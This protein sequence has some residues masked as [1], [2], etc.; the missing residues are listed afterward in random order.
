LQ[1][2]VVTHPKLFTRAVLSAVVLTALADVLVYGA[3]P[4]ISYGILA[5]AITAGILLC[6]GREGLGFKTLVLCALLGGI[7]VQ[8]LIQP[9]A[10]GFFVGILLVAVLSLHT[11][12]RFASDPAAF[13][14]R[15]FF[16]SLASIWLGTAELVGRISTGAGK[17]RIRAPKWW[18]VAVPAFLVLLF[19]MMLANANP[20]FNK[21]IS[22]AWHNTW[23]EVADI[24]SRLNLLRLLFWALFF[25]C[26]YGIIR[27]GRTIP[28]RGEPDGKPEKS[29]RADPRAEFLSCLLSMGGLNVLFVIVNL[30]DVI[31]LWLSTTL[32]EG[33][34][35]A[36]YAHTGSY[37]LIVTVIIS[38]VVVCAFYRKGTMQTR[39]RQARALVYIWVAQNIFL[40]LS[41]LRRL[42]IY[43]DAYG[44]TRWRIAVVFWVALVVCGFVLVIVKV[45]RN[46][47]AWRL[48]KANIVSTLI[49]FYIV[50]FL[51]LDS[52]VAHYN[53]D[54]YLQGRTK[55]MDVGYLVSLDCNALPA[56]AKLKAAPDP[57]VAKEASSYLRRATTRLQEESWDWR[58][59]YYRRSRVLS[60]LTTPPE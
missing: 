1:R 58:S 57:R 39:S 12:E 25:V 2:Y 15:S 41:A 11:V 13:L 50:G 29:R 6:R 28:A 60:E 38:A 54:R 4:G 7:A 44:L 43:I 23:V 16:S 37:R 8:F 56:I 5:A 59:W 24:L 17:S 52:L 32:P 51:N 34:T 3:A 42:L 46:W 10:S 47:S 49:L 45:A 35:Y 26:A 27:M 21:L 53:V 36:K 48:V 40:V 55:Q 19:G 18:I 22:T 31:Y 33:V 30:I 20:V 14:F 9:S